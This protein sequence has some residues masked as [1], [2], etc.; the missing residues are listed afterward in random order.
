MLILAFHSPVTS[1]YPSNQY[2]GL[3]LSFQY[4]D[5]GSAPIMDTNAGVLDSG[6]SLIFMASGKV[7]LVYFVCFLNSGIQLYISLL[8]RRVS[9]LRRRDRRSPRRC[10]RPPP[11]HNSP[12]QLPQITL[13]HHRRYHLRVHPQRADRPPR[14]QHRVPRR[15]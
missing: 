3:D 5:D 10:H 4:G 11:H 7:A 8:R 15:R 12:I 6:T 9:T 2:W 1:V 14:T 13:L